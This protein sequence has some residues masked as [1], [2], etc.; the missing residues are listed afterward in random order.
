MG[1]KSGAINIQAE[2]FAA[3]RLCTYQLIIHKHMHSAPKKSLATPLEIG[4]YV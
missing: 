1:E 2:G 3:A 4:S